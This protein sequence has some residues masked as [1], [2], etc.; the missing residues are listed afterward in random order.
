MAQAHGSQQL[1]VRR[2]EGV[3][4]FNA[5]FDLEDNVILRI[6]RNAPPFIQAAL[7]EAAAIQ[8]ARLLA[9][10]TSGSGVRGAT[11]NGVVAGLAG[12]PARKSGN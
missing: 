3:G 1:L 2:I 6:P 8:T 5:I 4:I 12:V 10:G 11:G 9:P 7:K